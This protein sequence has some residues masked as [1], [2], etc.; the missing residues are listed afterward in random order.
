MSVCVCVCVCLCACVYVCVSGVAACGVGEGAT[1]HVHVDEICVAVAAFGVGHVRT[2]AVA[3]RGGRL[4]ADAP[5]HPAG[6]Q[7]QGHAGELVARVKDDGVAEGRDAPR[8]WAHR[9]QPECLEKRPVASVEPQVP[10]QQRVGPVAKV[11]QIVVLPHAPVAIQAV[12]DRR[13]NAERV[14]RREPLRARAQRPRH[15]DQHTHAQHKRQL[16]LERDETLQAALVRRP[17]SQPRARSWR[18]RQ[19]HWDWQQRRRVNGRQC[20]RRVRRYERRGRGGRPRRD[21]GV[22]GRQARAHNVGLQVARH[23]DRHAHVV[24]PRRRRQHR[25]P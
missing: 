16:V 22:A 1:D 7:V 20:G 14:H 23:V 6:Q 19:R 21:R 11:K 12:R 9:K 8:Q 4:P 2:V 15:Q 17:P 18:Q 5:A 13:D 10:Q 25:L 24:P 3:E